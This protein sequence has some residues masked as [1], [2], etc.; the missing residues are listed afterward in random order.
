MNFR[1]P[2]K[3]LSA[4]F[5]LQNLKVTALQLVSCSQLSSISADIQLSLP[6]DD[7]TSRIPQRLVE[8]DEDLDGDFAHETRI[9]SPTMHFVPDAT[10]DQDLLELPGIKTLTTDLPSLSLPRIFPSSGPVTRPVPQWPPQGPSLFLRQVADKT[11]KKETN[12]RK[13]PRTPKTP[14]K[15]AKTEAAVTRPQRSTQKIKTR[16]SAAKEQST[17]LSVK[18]ATPQKRSPTDVTAAQA[19]LGLMTSDE[20]AMANSLAAA[21]ALPPSPTPESV[22]HVATALMMLSQGSDTHEAGDQTIEIE[23]TEEE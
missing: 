12:K 14:T 9:P 13:A 18:T 4:H 15:R 20:L 7:D 22:A 17:P 11:P 6:S 2:N 19:L 10:Q 1:V 21:T 23:P 5:F 3:V 16:K 8:I